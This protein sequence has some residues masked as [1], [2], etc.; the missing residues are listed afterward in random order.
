MCVCVC[1]CTCVLMVLF[2]PIPSM[3]SLSG[4]LLYMMLDSTR[5]VAMSLTGLI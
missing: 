4:H 2:K 1:V 3:H 5:L